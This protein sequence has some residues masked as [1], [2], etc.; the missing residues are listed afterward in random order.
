MKR[1]SLQLAYIL[2]RRAYRETSLLLEIFSFNHGRLALL[3]RGVKQ[4]RSPK[5]AILQPFIPLFLSW[6]GKGELPLLTEV[7][8]A[9][10]M[11]F[12]QGK[13]LY[14][15]FYCN[16]LLVALLGKYDAHPEIFNAYQQLLGALKQQPLDEVA[17]RQFEQEL[18]QQL[19]YGVLPHTLEHAHTEIAANHSY[20]YIP[21]QGL[22]RV[23]EISH[24]MGNA[25]A[26]EDLLAIVRQQWNAH[27]LRVAKQ[28][29][30]IALHSLLGNKPIHSRRLFIHFG[31]ETYANL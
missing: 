13:N 10:E 11:S 29:M 8:L 1:E 20:Q 15:G 24:A 3:A 22:V 12:L 19:G 5:Q 7:E 23:E 14:S 18:L 2:H 25:F 6:T 31:E 4:K 16:E 27:T 28:L 9:G 30:R 17:L 26:G 21:E